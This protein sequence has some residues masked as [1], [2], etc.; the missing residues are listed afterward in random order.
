MASQLKGRAF[1]IVSSHDLRA[2]RSSALSSAILG[3]GPALPLL[4]PPPLAL[5]CALSSK[6]ERKK[7]KHN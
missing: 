3:V 5:M 6:K 4:L 7:L 1:D 2:V